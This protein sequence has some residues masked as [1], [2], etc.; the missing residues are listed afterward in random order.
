MMPTPRTCLPIIRVHE[1]EIHGFQTDCAE[2]R[3]EALMTT[4]KP[5]LLHSDITSAIIG[6]LFDVHTELGAGFLE[7]VYANALAVLLRERGWHVEREVPFD[8][9]FHG[10][11]VGRY[12]ADMIVQSKVVVEVKGGRF[13][14]PASIAQLINYLRV[15]D[16]DV[17]LL[18]NFGLS[19]DFKRVVYTKGRLAIT[20]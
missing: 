3:G 20:S 5:E 9:M 16:L 1:I 14:D 2:G 4:E 12:R 13:K 18:L 8:V 15:A 11:H 7:S 17:G 10:V 19:A 6:G